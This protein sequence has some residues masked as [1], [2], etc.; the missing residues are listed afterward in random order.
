MR[1]VYNKL[2][3]E[4]LTKMTWQDLKNYIDNQSKSNKDFLKQNVCVYNYD[5]GQEHVADIIELLTE[6]LEDSDSGWVSYIS[7]NDEV[8]N[9]QIKKASVA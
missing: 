8:E 7:I 6:K 3:Q 1:L 4:T 5:D 9:G 2:T